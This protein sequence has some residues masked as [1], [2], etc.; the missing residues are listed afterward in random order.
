VVEKATQSLQPKLFVEI[1]K[2]GGDS[3][4]K[5]MEQAADAAKFAADEDESM[6]IMLIIIWG[7]EIAFY[8]YY[9]YRTELEDKG[10]KNYKGLIP[11]AQK[12]PK[13]QI[14]NVDLTNIVENLSHTAKKSTEFETPCIFNLTEH[15][16]IIHNLFE[17]VK[18]NNTREHCW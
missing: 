3:L 4:K 2:L 7:N 11:L 13:G 18:N 10:V 16:D 9:N 6:S 12:V 14:E 1:N 5:T 8:E 15:G 17:Y